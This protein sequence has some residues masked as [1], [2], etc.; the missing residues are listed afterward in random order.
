IVFNQQNPQLQ[1]L[2][3][4]SSRHSKDYGLLLSN[5]THW[6]ERLAKVRAGKVRMFFE[7]ATIGRDARG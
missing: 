5:T 7:P 4:F 1:C 6:N 3:C 2:S